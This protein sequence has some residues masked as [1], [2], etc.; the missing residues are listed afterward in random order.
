MVEPVSEGERESFARKLKAGFVA[1]VALSATLVALRAGGPLPAL[2]GAAGV[3][4]LVGVVLL[5]LAFPAFQ[6]TGGRQTG[7]RRD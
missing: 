7:R 3:G 2:A 5:R 1:L 6:R 4:V